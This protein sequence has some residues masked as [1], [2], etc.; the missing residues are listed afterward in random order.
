[1]Q[2]GKTPS[3]PELQV[4]LANLAPLDVV[5]KLGQGYH[6]EVYLAKH[7]TSKRLV[8]CKLIK[9]STLELAEQLRL[10]CQL[11]QLLHHNDPTHYSACEMQENADV[12]YLI[13]NY[14]PATPLSG[15]IPL[16]TDHPIARTLHWLAEASRAMKNLHDLGWSHG[17]IS[18]ANLLVCSTNDLADDIV[19]C[20]FSLTYRTCQPPTGRVR[21]TP[22]TLPPEVAQGQFSGPASD[23]YSLACIAYYLLTGRFPHQGNSSIE[24]CWK[25]IHIAPQPLNPQMTN[26]KDFPHSISEII[27]QS[28]AKIPA[29]RATLNDWL[30]ALAAWQPEKSWHRYDACK[31]WQTNLNLLPENQASLAYPLSNPLANPEL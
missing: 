30:A 27:M 10:E 13:W 19:L 7:R 9:Q 4:K 18:P 16:S 23:V 12:P 28:L 26:C 1:M 17:D 20:D 25:Q 2:P 31:W 3:A 8:V 14:I 24:I 15:L 29:D 21:G 6:S 22:L 11:R 5:C